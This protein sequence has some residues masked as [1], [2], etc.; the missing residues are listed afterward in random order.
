M[1]GTFRMMRTLRMSGMLNDVAHFTEFRLFLG[2]FFT[3]NP[4]PLQLFVDAAYR[5]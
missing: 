5:F 3:P 1:T 2:A 4:Y